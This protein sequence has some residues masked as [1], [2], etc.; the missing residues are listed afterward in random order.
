M[1]VILGVY[2]IALQCASISSTEESVVV[3]EY[4]GYMGNN[5]NSSTP[6]SLQAYNALS[7]KG[8]T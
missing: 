6:A 2:P 1:S 7:A 5:S 4:C 3:V 8:G